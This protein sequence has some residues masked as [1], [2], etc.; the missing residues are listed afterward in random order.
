HPVPAGA[1][2]PL[3]VALHGMGETVDPVTG[4]NGW[5]KSYELDVAMMNLCHPPLEREA[6]RGFVTTDRLTEINSS[7]VKRPFAGLVVACPYVPS[8]IGGS[9]LSF[10][11]YGAWIADTLMPKLR[12]E[13]PIEGTAR[14]TGIDGVS[15]GGICSLRIGLGRPDLFGVVGALQPA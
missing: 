10:D 5:L 14:A 1:R 8:S 7:L 11:A 4:A 3:L 2:L 13:T 9:D 12:D 6:F 15:L